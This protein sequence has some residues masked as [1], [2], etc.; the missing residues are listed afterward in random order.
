M[1]LEARHSG[2]PS[3]RDL[4]TVICE[5]ETDGG[6]SGEEKCTDGKT[7]D[8]EQC[9]CVKTIVELTLRNELG[10]EIAVML[11]ESHSS[12]HHILYRWPRV[13]EV[14]SG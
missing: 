3:S 14:G 7:N 6:W 9:T 11:S 12:N 13:Y 8:Q 2:R 4:L 1:M 10:R 5:L